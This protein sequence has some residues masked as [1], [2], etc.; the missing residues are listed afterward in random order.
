LE[1]I[2]SVIV[3]CNTINNIDKNGSDR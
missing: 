3:V 2:I 1:K